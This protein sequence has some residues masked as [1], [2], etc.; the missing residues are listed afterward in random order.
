MGRGFN[1]ISLPDFDNPQGPQPFRLKLNATR[2]ILE[3][4][5]IGGNVPNRGSKGQN[6]IN[7]F[8]LTYLQRVSDSS[9]NG[10]MHIEPGLWLHVP[11]T[12]VPE[13]PATVVR[14]GSIP[15]GTSILAQG[16][17]IPTVNGGPRIQAVDSTP[18][19]AMGPIPTQ[20]IWHPS[21]RP[22]CLRAFDHRSSR[23]RIWL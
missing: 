6:D 9:S 10:A 15:H 3:F 22:R 21:A 7:I 8:G 2:E 19:N 12:T 23:T 17:V 16:S 13:Q 11:S 20:H 5:H 18:F 4:Q 1:L 14:Q